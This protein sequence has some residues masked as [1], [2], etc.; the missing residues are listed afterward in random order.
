MTTYNAASLFAR[1]RGLYRRQDA[2]YEQVSQHPG[3]VALPPDS[4]G[5]SL[6]RRYDD[7]EV[8]ADEGESLLPLSVTQS[9]SRS[10]RNRMN[11]GLKIT[12]AAML[13]LVAV[14]VAELIIRASHETNHLEVSAST[15]PTFNTSLGCT[16]APFIYTGVPALFSSV[17]DPKQAGHAIDFLGGT[18]GT[19]TVHQA[20][21]NETEVSYEMTLRTNDESLL[22]Q[23]SVDFLDSRVLVS[24]PSLAS[25]SSSSSHICARFDVKMYVPWN[26]KKLHIASHTPTQIL[27]DEHS[28]LVLDRL[29]VTLFALSSKNLIIAHA[30]IH[31]THLALETYNGWITGEASIVEETVVSTQRGGGSV[32]LQVTPAPPPPGAK[33]PSSGETSTNPSPRT[34][35][36]ETSTGSGTTE[37]TFI[38][39]SD[40]TRPFRAEHRSSMNGDVILNYEQARF[41]G[42]LWLDTKTSKLRGV[43]KLVEE[44]DK[45]EEEREKADGWTHFAG[46]RHGGDVVY[47]SS[48]GWTGLTI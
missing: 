22:E 32:K 27:F 37:V 1:I 41:N 5:P 16:T 18:P 34:A 23:V 12:I 6:S 10:S 3:A 7:D 25:S 38:S 31:A 9:T 2:T 4:L 24:T 20:P 26:L 14:G 15:P 30:N 44:G 39:S 8:K 45:A 48:R 19:I 43:H 29:Y 17:V 11:I 42:M 33:S 36:F 35:L 40:R 13:L 47:V 21:P 28:A 46:D